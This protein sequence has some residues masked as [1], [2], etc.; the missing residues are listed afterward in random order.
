LI[1]IEV[2]MAENDISK[3][4]EGLKKIVVGGVTVFKVKG[5][6]KTVPPSIH[7]SKG[8]EMFTPEFSDKYVVLVVLPDT[9]MAEAIKVVRE[10]S[11][12]G[13]IFVTPVIH[14]VDLATGV[15]GEEAI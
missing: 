13:K 3:V 1:K 5:R 12:I 15:E 9:K 10:Y 11:K 7:A 2:I 4:S 8:T 6:G 14:A